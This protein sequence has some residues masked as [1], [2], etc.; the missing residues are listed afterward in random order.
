MVQEKVAIRK[1]ATI[2][3]YTM[4]RKY[5]TEEGVALRKRHASTRGQEQQTKRASR[6]RAHHDHSNKHSLTRLCPTGSTFKQSLVTS[7]KNLIR[8]AYE[9]KIIRIRH[10]EIKPDFIR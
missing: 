4:S 8:L 3:T 7:Y 5:A 1:E 10:T 2:E 6:E 9:N